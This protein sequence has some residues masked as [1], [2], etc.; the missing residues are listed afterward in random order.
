MSKSQMCWLAGEGAA[1][2]LAFIV[3]FARIQDEFFY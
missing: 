3:W 1:G 2:Q